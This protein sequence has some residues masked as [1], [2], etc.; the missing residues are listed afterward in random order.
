MIALG[1]RPVRMHH[2]LL[3]QAFW[4]K[5]TTPICKTTCSQHAALSRCPSP[6]IS[7]VRPLTNDWV[8]R[9][10]RDPYVKQ[11]TVQGYRSRAAIKL[12]Q[13][14]AKLKLL[15]PGLLA[16]D[17]GAAPGSWSQVLAKRGVEVVA[18]DLLPIDP[19]EGVAI[20]QGDIV[21]PAVG[22]KIREILK[23]RQVD[24]VF[25]DMSPDRSGHLS[26]DH[27]RLVALIVKALVLARELLRPG[28][29]VL[30]KALQGEDHQ[31]MIAAMRKFG[32]VAMHKPAASRQES[33]EVYVSLRGFDPD[34]FDS[35]REELLLVG[36]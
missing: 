1:H 35:A 36:Y 34:K 24:L 20:V 8:K 4:L 3:Q 11:A 12:E 21:E 32:K 25:S 13:L 27:C 15:R 17:L 14:D 23:G 7:G 26:L 10:M 29:A 22:Q 9:H 33:A 31:T 28:G 30:V 5:P 19:I 16:L 18:V 2:A 6:F